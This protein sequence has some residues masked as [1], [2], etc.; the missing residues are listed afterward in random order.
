MSKLVCTVG[1]DHIHSHGGKAGCE[2]ASARKHLSVAGRICH[3]I[4]G[5][6]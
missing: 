4:S 2:E 1:L 3:S 6:S 5:G